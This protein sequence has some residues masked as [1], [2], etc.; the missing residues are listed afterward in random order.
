MILPTSKFLYLC[1]KLN[2][3][4]L[5]LRSLHLFPASRLKWILHVA[6]DLW[7]QGAAGHMLDFVGMLSLLTIIVMFAPLQ[8]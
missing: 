3:G 8:I 2:H 6:L 1:F 4:L 7:K 5:H